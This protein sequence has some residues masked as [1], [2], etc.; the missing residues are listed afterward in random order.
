MKSVRKALDADSVLATRIDSFLNRYEENIIDEEAL[1][2]IFGYLS[3]GYGQLSGPQQSSVK[4]AI[5]KLIE[6]FGIKLESQWSQEDQNV[7]D[8][9]NTL[10]G[11]MERGETITEEELSG[12][13]VSEEKA[14]EVAEE[15]T[16]D[17][18]VAS[19][20]EK[21][22]TAERENTT[23]TGLSELDEAIGRTGDSAAQ[24]V[25]NAVFKSVRTGKLRAI[26]KQIRDANKSKKMSAEDKVER[27]NNLEENYN[28]E[29]E[30]ISK[31]RKE[32]RAKVDAEL[33]RLQPKLDEAKKKEGLAEVKK[34]QAAITEQLSRDIREVKRSYEKGKER[35]DYIAMLKAD[36]EVKR[37]ALRDDIAE[38]RGGKKKAEPTVEEEVTEV[39]STPEVEKRT[40]E[41]KERI[42]KEKENLKTLKQKLAEA[43][44]DLKE[45]EA[46][47]EKKRGR[48]ERDNKKKAVADIE[49]EIQESTKNIE[50]L[51]AEVSSMIP[52]EVDTGTVRNRVGKEK[53]SAFET[54]V[55]DLLEYTDEVGEEPTR[56][57]KNALTRRKTKVAKLV[58]E[59]KLSPAEQAVVQSFVQER[60]NNKK[61][62]EAKRKVEQEKN[63][64][65]AERGKKEDTL[66]TLNN[67]L[68]Q[69]TRELLKL[70]DV[71]ATESMK[72]QA[73][74]AID[75][76]KAEIDSLMADRPAKDES[77]VV[78]T[79]PT[80]KKKPKR[81]Y[82]PT[83]DKTTGRK[84]TDKEL[85]QN[86]IVNKAFDR[87][88]KLGRSKADITKRRYLGSLEAAVP[89]LN[90]LI[91][92]AERTGDNLL[93]EDLR[94]VRANVGRAMNEFLDK[95]E[96]MSNEQV[97][98]MEARFESPYYE[99]FEALKTENPLN[100]W[101]KTYVEA[102]GKAG[103]VLYESSSTA[104]ASPVLK[105]LIEASEEIDEINK[106]LD[107]LEA[108][109]TEAKALRARQKELMRVASGEAIAEKQQT[110]AAEEVTEEQLKVER[111][112]KE[113]LSRQT[114]R[115]IKKHQAEVK[116]L[117]EKLKGKRGKERKPLRDAELRLKEAKEFTDNLNKMSVNEALRLR[118]PVPSAREQRVK[119]EQVAERR[120]DLSALRVI[121][122]GSSRV[123]YDLGDGRALK[124]ALNAKGLEQN[125]TLAPWDVESNLKGFVPLVFEEG[126]DYLVVENLPFDVTLDDGR[127]GASAIDGFI[128]GLEQAYSRGPGRLQEYL[129]EYKEGMGNFVDYEM[130]P[131]DFKR[132]DSWGIRKDGTIVL[133]DEGALNPSVNMVSEPTAWAVEDFAEVE[134]NRGYRGPRQTLNK[135]SGQDIEYLLSDPNTDVVAEEG[136]VILYSVVDPSSVV[137]IMQEGISSDEEFSRSRTELGS[138]GSLVAVEV[139]ADA[140]SVSETGIVSVDGPIPVKR[141]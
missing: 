107:K 22:A 19:L 15:T 36:A 51:E 140:V 61:E 66:R 117:K 67:Q 92:A 1:A 127:S 32:A 81:E 116:K 104:E 90:G 111:Q 80:P 109:S 137:R 87:I 141:G 3:E 48:K 91:S 110:E 86:E 85:K 73:K 24:R 28:T 93:V 53:Y 71:G 119:S 124:V 42:V 34:K 35:D 20:Q 123:V 100:A 7:I 43:K 88:K 40:A 128:Y 103:I 14:E 77:P 133:V 125:Q 76:I 13:D 5:K 21:R 26:E 72:T 17:N 130:L 54:A 89:R 84:L 65:A 25:Y 47:E 113:T 136:N 131:G 57:Q 94:A 33:K 121:G 30:R 112:R 16:V 126:P 98:A 12:L 59:L 45:F 70:E 49:S 105:E 75:A 108:S 58:A 31:A 41:T 82:D 78:D 139:P 11:K 23:E 62:A 114:Q 2:E 101:T 46:R 95:T 44:R 37:A 27:I 132:H 99:F 63:K 9:L 60:V 79:E 55:R 97:E 83:V 96:G 56:G 18:R 10:S 38:L 118:T 64:A 39:E 106:K 122:K 4:T 120:F 68:V 8:V 6:L 138:D 50:E 102:L 115:D 129:E 29:L 69:A 74:S 135:Y 52:T 134:K